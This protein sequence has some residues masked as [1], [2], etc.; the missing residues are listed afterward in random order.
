MQEDILLYQA[1]LIFYVLWHQTDLF[2]ALCSQPPEV[3]PNFRPKLTHRVAPSI[4][5]T[6]FFQVQ[7]SQTFVLYTSIY[8]RKLLRSS[9]E[10][11]PD[12]CPRS[13]GINHSWM[14]PMWAR[15]LP[16]WFGWFQEC[17]HIGGWTSCWT[18][19]GGCSSQG[20]WGESSKSKRLVS[21]KPLL[22]V[23]IHFLFW[24]L[25]PPVHTKCSACYTYNAAK[26]PPNPW[27]RHP[28]WHA[29]FYQVWA[30]AKTAAGV[31]VAIDGYCYS[32][33]AFTA[34]HVGKRTGRKAVTQTHEDL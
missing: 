12:T 9:L 21:L 19:I 22:N 13:F 34:L 27:P 8:K 5:L 3:P 31:A 7:N 28:V 29:V 32:N 4:A 20:W 25:V 24:S 16:W 14:V 18:H 10:P 6:I 11:F 17:I 26:N 33:I 1:S 15:H 30:C 23:F 2:Y